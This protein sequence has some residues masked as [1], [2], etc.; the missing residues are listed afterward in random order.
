[1]Y[2]FEKSWGIFEI[3]CVKCNLTVCKVTFNCKLQ[4]RL[5]EQD[6]LL[7]LLIILLGKQV[8]PLLLPCFRSSRS[9]PIVCKFV[10]TVY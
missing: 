1:M 5:A 3:F 6:V 4:K 7:A 10:T 2:F 8:L 9:A